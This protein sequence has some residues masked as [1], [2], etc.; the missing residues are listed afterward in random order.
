MTRGVRSP[1]T[2]RLRQLYRAG[3]LADRSGVP[4]DELADP[5]SAAPTTTL[6]R[7]RFLGAAG[8]ALGASALGLWRPAQATP[9]HPKVAI[10]GAGAAGLAC[11]VRLHRFGISA[12]VYEANSRLGGRILTSRGELSDDVIVERG[13]EFI[14]SEHRHTR[15]LASRLG[16]ELETVDGGAFPNGGDEV[17]LIDGEVYTAQQAQAD[18]FDAKVWKVLKSAVQ[19]APYP[20]TFNSFNREHL[21][22]DHLNLPD[23]LD[24]VGIGSSSRLGRLM[25]TNAMVE[26]G[27]APE[28]QTCLNLIYI[29]GYN[30]PTLQP[31]P[32]TDEVYHLVGGNDRLITRAAES[33]PDGTIEREHELIAIAGHEDGPYRMHFRNRAPADC[34]VLVLALPFTTLRN[35]DIDS[36]IWSSFRP[37]KRRAIDNLFLGT[38]GKLHAQT[39][40]RTWIRSLPGDPARVSNGIAYSD[41]DDFICTWDATAYNTS[42]PKPVLVQF[43]AGQLGAARGGEPFGAAEPADTDRFLSQIDHLFPGTSAAYTGNSLISRWSDNPWSKGAYFSPLLGDFTSF[44]GAPALPERNIFFCGEHTELDA[45]GFI[46]GAVKTGEQAANDIHFRY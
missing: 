42:T 46:E 17:Y 34:D 45:F 12:K 22:L 7:R 19:A 1:M 40:D 16:L 35:V 2:G 20:P 13:G 41:P 31:L 5:Q 6:S 36:R 11:A 8:A 10:V 37:A 21:R 3:I 44:F 33:L 29:L 43:L 27:P 38:N 32:G 25:Q 28:E 9:S 14:S 4:F 26:Y 39:T 15:R 23:W 18:W 30:G 24:E